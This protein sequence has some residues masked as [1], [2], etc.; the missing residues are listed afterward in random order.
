MWSVRLV[1]V[2]AAAVGASA[3]YSEDFFSS[4]SRLEQLVSQEEVV[5][6]R[7]ERYLEEAYHSLETVRRSVT[8]VTAGGRAITATA[9][10]QTQ[11]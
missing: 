7:L 2:A 1:M 6:D 10:S 8:A 3:G 5:V 4:T 9:S 11:P